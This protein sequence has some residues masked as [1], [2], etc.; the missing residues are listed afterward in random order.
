MNS[1]YGKLVEKK[2][3]YDTHGKIKMC[4]DYSFLMSQIL[5][6]W[7]RWTGRKN[8]QNC[9]D[10]FFTVI[11]FDLGLFF[12]VYQIFIAFDANKAPTIWI[13]FRRQWWGQ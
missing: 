5:Q 9:Y 3:V 4:F 10:I 13:R 2:Q 1:L 12:P 7:I 8:L 6:Y 11:T